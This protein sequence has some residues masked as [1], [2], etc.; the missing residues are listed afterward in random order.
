MTRGFQHQDL[1]LGYFVQ[2]QAPA[3]QHG[4]KA[5]PKPLP[6]RAPQAYKPRP[7]H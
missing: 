4:Q 1:G 6:I 3:P 2:K 5:P 7:G